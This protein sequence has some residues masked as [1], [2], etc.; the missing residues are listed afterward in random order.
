MTPKNSYQLIDNFDIAAT[1]DNDGK[2]IDNAADTTAEKSGKLIYNVTTTAP[3]DNAGKLIQVMIGRLGDIQPSQRNKFA[4]KSRGVVLKFIL[5]H[6]FYTVTPLIYIRPT[7]LYFKINTRPHL[8]YSHATAQ[9]M[10]QIYI[11]T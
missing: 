5:D 8:L 4:T 9:K 2:L 6:I 1:A 3:A 11:S 7:F 10:P